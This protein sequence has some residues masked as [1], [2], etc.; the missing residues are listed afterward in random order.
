MTA[1]GSTSGSA[2]ASPGSPVRG[3]T[4]PPS[5]SSAQ[6]DPGEW[7]TTS[8]GVQDSALPAPV[9][10]SSPGS[11]AANGSESP[12]APDQLQRPVTRLQHGIQNPKIRTDGI[13]RWCMAARSSVEEPGTVDEALHDKNW[14]V[15][16][17]SEHQALLKNKT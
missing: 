8:G 12:P 13:V 3:A 7:G 5:G 17:E 10:I 11:S 2:A 4:P 1:I 15:A 9:E 6:D 16:M 14:A